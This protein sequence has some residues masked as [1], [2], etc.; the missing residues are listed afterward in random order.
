VILDLSDVPAIDGTAALAIEDML[1]IVRAHRQQLYFVGM[2]PGVG[3]VLEGLGVLKH[4]TPEQR[5]DFRLDA[6]RHAEE[7]SGPVPVGESSSEGRS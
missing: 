4:I 1:R 5:Y 7:A 6:L 3:R 2:K